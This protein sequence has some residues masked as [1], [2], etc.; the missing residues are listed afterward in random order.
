LIRTV[1]TTLNIPETAP[2]ARANVPAAVMKNP[3]VW[4]NPR[5]A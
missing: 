5:H 2:M 1:L 4:S 3:G